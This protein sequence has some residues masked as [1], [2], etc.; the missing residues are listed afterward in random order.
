[1]IFEI[2]I[3]SI[4]GTLLHFTYD[5]SGH[6]KIVALFSSVNESTW[7]HIKM[8]LSAT[9]IVSIFDGILHG[10][11]A[12]Y[13]VGKFCSLIIIILV[14]PLIFYT[15][16][17]IFKKNIVIIDILSFYVAIILSQVIFYKFLDMRAFEYSCRFI[18]IVGV[19]VIF[20]F[21]MVLTLFPIKNFIF[22]DPITKEYGLKGHK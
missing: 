6:N 19:F 3:I 17:K 11:N 22:I 20:G 2:I 13:F 10:S 1:M 8:A 4:L 16:K 18:S 9:F 15:Y 21:Y 5:W 7:E 12:N 14:I